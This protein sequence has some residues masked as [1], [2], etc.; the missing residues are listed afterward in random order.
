MGVTFPGIDTQMNEDLSIHQSIL[1]KAMRF[2]LIV[3]VLY[4][5][6]V[7]DFYGSIQCSL[8]GWN[9]YHF[10]SEMIS[11]NLC[12]IAV[13]WF[14][15]FSGYFFFYHLPSGRFSGKW[16][17]GKLKKRGRSLLIPYLFWNLFLVVA[18]VAKTGLFSKLGISQNDIEGELWTVRQGPIYWLVT[19]PA[20]FPLWFMR[21][22]MVM[23]LLVPLLWLLYKYLP[24]PACILF[25]VILY[26]IPFNA[27]FVSWRAYFFFS[28]GAFLGKNNVNMLSLCQKIKK[29]AAILAILSLI[30]A[31]YWNDAP[32]H[33]W[34]LRAFYPFGMIFFMNLC[35]WL[36]QKERRKE[37]LTKLAAPVF[38]IYAIHEIYLLGWTKGSFIR[39]FGDGLTGTWIK[40]L[41]VPLVVLAICLMLYWLLHK[42]MPKTLAFLC[43]G[44]A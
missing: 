42:L 14:F 13:C 37:R 8:D 38:F 35:N 36:I 31:S 15:V 27:P 10:F 32:F 34:L 20:N 28:F 4:A 29:P 5:H 26:F 41:F 22:L 44:H 16:Y 9:L 12:K 6:S 2:P 43:G 30:V 23:S 25:L 18:I 39:I 33:E 1:I 24:Q 21:D 19:G 3:L 7:G 11:H 40:F 17:A